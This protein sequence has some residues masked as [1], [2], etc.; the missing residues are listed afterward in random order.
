MASTAAKLAKYFKNNR[1]MIVF[2]LF[3]SVGVLV[4]YGLFFASKPFAFLQMRSAVLQPVSIVGLFC[5]IFLPLL[6]TYISVLINKP[7]LL[8]IISFIKAASFSFSLL[9]TSVL[10]ESATWLFCILFMF[11]DICFLLVLFHLWLQFPYYHVAK[12][13]RIFCCSAIFGLLIAL[14]DYFIVSPF[15]IGLF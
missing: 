6:C 12:S 14:G 13:K 3:W 5:A 15:L 8:L 2:S 9:C 4:G 11:S 1:Y 7:I 10:Y